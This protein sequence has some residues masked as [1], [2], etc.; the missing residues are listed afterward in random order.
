MESTCALLSNRDIDCWGGNTYGQLGN[1]TT[2]TSTTPVEV[3][4]FNITGA[5]ATAIAAG[6][7]ASCALVEN[8]GIDCWGYNGDGGLGDGTDTGPDSCLVSSTNANEPCS[9]TP[10]A[11]SGITNATAIAAGGGSTCALLAG[12]SVDCWGDNSS[13]EL[14]DGTDAGPDSCGHSPC[15]TAP[16]A[17]SGITG[18]SAITS[19]YSSSCALLSGGSVECW[20]G[21][22]SGELGDGTDTGPDSCGYGGCSTTPVAVSGITNATAIA[23]GG[24]STCALFSDGGVDCWGDN[25][26]G[27]L[28]NDTTGGE[29]TTPVAVSGLG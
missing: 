13:G 8:G 16:G 17:V 27:E 28:G 25:T 19:G 15:G 1:G 22:S 5:I 12:G 20:G 10:V 9:T 26:G 2:T 18:A 21:N 29:S 6:G 11:V 14:G 3:N 4:G 7:S 24:D 23:A